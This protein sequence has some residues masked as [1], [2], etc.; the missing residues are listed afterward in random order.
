VLPGIKLFQ[1]LNHPVTVLLPVFLGNISRIELFSPF[2][3]WRERG[4]GWGGREGEREW[5]REGG[6]PEGDR[7]GLES[8]LAAARARVHY[9]NFSEVSA[10]VHL[11]SNV[12]SERT[13]PARVTVLLVE[14]LGYR[15]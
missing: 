4:G 8:N 2:F 15:A 13:L 11:I 9:H 1:L 7:D 12:P 6:R 3:S 10:S 5:G 14:G